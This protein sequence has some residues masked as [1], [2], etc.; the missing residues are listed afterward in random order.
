MGHKTGWLALGS[1]LAG[2]AD[3][4][5]IPEIPYDIQVVAEAIRN[6]SKAG[7]RFSIIA[8]SEGAFSRDDFEMQQKVKEGDGKGYPIRLAPE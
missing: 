2:G 3:V 7:K 8:L 5:L 1:G 6:R 4:I